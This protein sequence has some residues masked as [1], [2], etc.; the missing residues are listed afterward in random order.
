MASGLCVRSGVDYG[1]LWGDV[2]IVLNEQ[3]T[4]GVAPT[5]D[6]L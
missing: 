3:A 5:V 1:S 2:V 4:C 6:V